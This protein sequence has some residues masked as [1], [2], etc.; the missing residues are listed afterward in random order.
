MLPRRPFSFMMF[1]EQDQHP[2]TKRILILPALAALFA[3]AC[4]PAAPRHDLYTVGIFQVTEA[5]TLGETRKGFIRAFE[6][7]GYR[8]GANI[9]F[10]VRNAMGDISE[11][12]RIAEA[13]D[14]DRV[15]LIVA[16]STQSLQAALIAG[17]KIPIVFASVANPYLVKA[18][19]SAEDHLPNVT[20]VASTAPIA[21]TLAFIRQVL[22]QARRIGTL[23]TPAEINSEYYLDLARREASRLKMEIVAIPIVNAGD[24]LFSAQLLVNKKVDAIY[25]ISD[26]TINAVFETIGLVAEE[27]GIPLFGGFASATRLGACAAM[28]WDFFEMGRKAGALALRVKAGEQPG[29]IPFQAMSDLRLSLNM[30]AAARQGVVFPEVVI[31]RANEILPPSAETRGN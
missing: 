24:V 22:P 13:F 17:T 30:T 6:D 26:N 3:A 16:L 21:E 28:G 23:W 19:R 18:G 1:L 20:G 9:R 27:N 31:G 11:V 15:D 8:D 2:L 29:R 7:Q 5:P 10:K 25:P 12:Q 4:S 14:R